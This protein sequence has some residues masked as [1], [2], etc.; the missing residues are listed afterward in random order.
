MS[1]DLLDNTCVRYVTAVIKVYDKCLIF[2]QYDV[3]QCNG[4]FVS[5]NFRE[6]SSIFPTLHHSLALPEE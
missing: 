5:I 1:G 3:F 6:S 2:E 4:I